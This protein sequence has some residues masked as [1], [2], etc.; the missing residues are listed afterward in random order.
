MDFTKEWRRIT[1]GK[2]LP[3]GCIIVNKE[4]AKAHPELVRSFINDYRDSV[5]FVNT[6]T[7]K[8]AGLIVKQKFIETEELAKKAIPRSK[9]VW[10]DAMKAKEDITFYL[11]ILLESNPKSVGGELPDDAFYYKIPK[12]E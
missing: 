2:Q 4:F 7:E 6:F 3:M 1:H 8:A 12:K 9:I 5:N 11:T 10:I